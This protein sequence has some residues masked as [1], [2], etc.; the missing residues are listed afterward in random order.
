MIN[1]DKLKLIYKFGRN[2]KWEDVQV[3]F[4]AAHTSSFAP[5]E[6]LIKEGEVKKKVFFIG[7]GMVRSFVVNNKG[8]EITTGIRW[9]NQYIANPE[10]I[11]FN[12][13]STR[14]FQALEPTNT[15][16]L[17]YEVLDSILNK[18]PKLEK[19]RRKVLLNLLQKI[20]YR[21]ESFIL[22]SPEERYV[23]LIKSNPAII[24]RVHNKYIANILGVT[25]VSLSRIRKRIS[26]K[27]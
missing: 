12:K 10:M 24:D 8:E 23:E 1:F 18:N 21:M 19:A 9:E 17:E 22:L 5:G 7:T 20:F 16:W 6:Y 15:Y 11:L 3:L 25:P 27:K 26:S 14:Y 13:P 4:D 2:L